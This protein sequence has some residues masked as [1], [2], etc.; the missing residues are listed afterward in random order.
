MKICFTL[1]DVL[2]AK[3]VQIGKIYQKCINPDIDLSTLDFSTNDYCSIFNFKN[4]AEYMKFLY[5]D[6]PF[7]IFG[8]ANMVTKMLDKHLNLW[9]IDITNRDDLHENVE[10]MLSNPMEF[11]NSI[12]FTYFFLSKA[13]TRIREVYFPADSADIWNRC[14]VLVTADPKLIE[15]KPEGKVCIKIE[16]SYNKDLKADYS[17]ENLDA[18]LQDKEII[19]TLTSKREDDKNVG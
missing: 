9:H 7:E 14:D 11:N 2:R 6:Y 10:V 4:K 12:G 8:E 16:T 5:E 19:E 18:F 15:T 1:D 3:T 17:Y 13:A